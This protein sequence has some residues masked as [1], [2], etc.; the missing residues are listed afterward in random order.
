[1]LLPAKNGVIDL[2]TGKLLPH[3]PTYFFTRSIPVYYNPSAKCPIWER[4]I[5]EMM[6]RPIGLDSSDDPTEE[7]EERQRMTERSKELVTFLRRVFGHS[8]TGIVSEKILCILWGQ[9][10]NGKSLLLKILLAM[11]G[12]FGMKATTDLFLAKPGGDKLRVRRMRED[13]WEFEPTHHIFMATNPL[14]VIRDSTHAM[15]TRIRLIPFT[16]TFHD[17][18]KAPR[19]ILD[20]P[21]IPKQDKGLGQKLLAELPGI[22]AWCV[23]GCL[24]WQ[25]H[26]LTLPDEVRVA[27]DAYRDEE[28]NVTEFT[29]EACLVSDTVSDRA[30]NLF[31][32]YQKWCEY[33]EQRAYD[34]KAFGKG[35][36]SLGFERT[37]RKGVKWYVGIKANELDVS[38]TEK[39]SKGIANSSG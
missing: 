11:F 29:K 28:N 7:L 14:P 5:H 30:K 37:T 32:A 39:D 27:T 25:K 6:G 22:L 33:N 9:G 13:T 3:S 26:G 15:W 35:L 23:R 19:T 20:N 36:V 10:D 31:E 18:D 17:P 24:D 38:D 12:D 4:A 16:V 21:R 2:E 8:L 1:M 34:Q